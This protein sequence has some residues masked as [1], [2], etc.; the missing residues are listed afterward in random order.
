M[1][2]RAL[3]ARNAALTSSGAHSAPSEPGRFTNIPSGCPQASP[4]TIQPK[5][6][7]RRIGR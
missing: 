7:E 1:T 5:V 6:G 4:A 3:R 2:F